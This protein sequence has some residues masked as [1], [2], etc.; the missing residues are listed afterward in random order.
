M[1]SNPPRSNPSYT[2]DAAPLPDGAG[3][4]CARCATC[5]APYV[6][7]DHRNR[8]CSQRCADKPR[9][10]AHYRD[11]ASARQARIAVRRAGHDPSAEPWR[12]RL[13]TLAGRGVVA[14]WREVV[15]LPPGRPT[16]AT[17]VAAPVEAPPPV[18]AAQPVALHAAHPAAHA[19]RPAPWGA[20]VGEQPPYIAATGIPLG[21]TPRL[22]TTDATRRHLHGLVSRLIG[23]EHHPTLA[24][25]ALVPYG[26]GWG[27]VA[28]TSAGRRA[29]LGIDTH[30]QVG[31]TRAHLTTPATPV[32][33][34][35]PPVYAPG[36]Y[37]VRIE[38]LALVC[39]YSNGRTTPRLTPARDTILAVA[40]QAL[41]YAGCT[42]GH[43]H[44]E[45][46]DARG[47]H[48]DCIAL[49]G[50]LG[51]MRGWTGVVEVVCN[52]P[53]A[54]ALKLCEH[55][56]MGARIAYGLGRVRVEVTAV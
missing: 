21:L 47:A 15:G 8:F 10:A 18:G 33:L 24:A 53:V 36:R 19:P 54:W 22:P 9:N 48:A 43:H 11:N 44:V 56:G 30:V 1:L 23:R 29:L 28:L 49:G 4:S 26:Q 6:P 2:D 7:Q 35:T 34:R 13:A 40:S 14:G 16:R 39:H 46:V 52:A 12:S 55:V 50:H 41:L 45:A 3:E 51:F 20:P 27:V 25:W 31:S 37:R 42:T 5:G 17:V 32:R 38:A